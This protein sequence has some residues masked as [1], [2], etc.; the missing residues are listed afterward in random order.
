MICIIENNHA[1][2]GIWSVWSSSL[3]PTVDSKMSQNVG[4][5]NSCCF[6]SAGNWA[7]SKCANSGF[8]NLNLSCS[9]PLRNPRNCTADK[10]LR[11]LHLM[12][13]FHQ[14]G[15][16]GAVWLPRP[17][18]NF[19][20]SDFSFWLQFDRQNLKLNLFPAQ[21]CRISTSWMFA[22]QAGNFAKD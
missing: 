2:S 17:M 11:F 4:V 21:R 20:L 13:S 5:H 15:V 1:G 3:S 22:W 9:E 12:L 19:F 14:Y 16:T 8:F 10:V 18:H 6:C 7:A